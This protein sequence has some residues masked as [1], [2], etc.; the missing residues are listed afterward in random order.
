MTTATVPSTATLRC[1][2]E[3]SDQV[4]FEL[5]FD[6]EAIVHGAAHAREQ[7]CDVFGRRA[8]DVVD[9]VGVQRR[10][11]RAALAPSLSPGRFDQAARPC[12]LR[13]C[14][15]R[16]R[17]WAA[18]SAASSC[19]ERAASASPS[20]TSRALARGKRQRHAR[21][22]DVARERRVP[23]EVA[24]ADADAARGGSATAPRRRERSRRS[25][26][27]CRHSCAASRRPSRECRRANRCRSAPADAA[28]AVTSAMSAEPPASTTTS[29]VLGAHAR[30]RRTRRRAERRRRARRRRRR[31]RCC[32][33]R[34]IHHGILRRKQKRMSSPE[35]GSH[36]ATVT[37]ASA[38][39]PIFHDV[40]G[41]SGSSKRRAF[42]EILACSA[43][44]V[45][46]RQAAGAGPAPS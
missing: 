43:V 26:G 33:C 3:D 36:S 19:G 37:N 23:V 21:N 8:A 24:H 10:D 41:A 13:G 4:H 39:P 27:R 6:P 20:R 28:L 14:G 31:A 12:R 1:I 40:Y 38:G 16:S 30:P 45:G 5:Q 32:R 42:A 35:F 25:R 2:D 46:Q 11:F 44:R 18:R 34:C 17:R 7:R 9:E 22:D 29:S 15:S